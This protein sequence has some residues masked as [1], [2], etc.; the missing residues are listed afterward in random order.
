MH[1]IVFYEDKNGISPVY[2]YI[3]SFES[4]TDKDNKMNLKKIREYIMILS[5]H[6]KSAGEPFIKHIEDDIWEIRP[7]KN[8][9][10]FASWTNNSFILLHYFK[11]K[12]RKTPSNEIKQAKRNLKEIRE[13][14][15]NQ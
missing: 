5:I 7:I 15:N 1:E 3:K 12:T 9:I 6:G 11:K 2:D 8:R 14:S 4:R 13:R 10:F